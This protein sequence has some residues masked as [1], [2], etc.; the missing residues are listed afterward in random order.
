MAEYPTT[1]H[2]RQAIEK[3][4]ATLDI[5]DAHVEAITTQIFASDAM[6]NMPPGWD[7]QRLQRAALAYTRQAVYRS[8]IGRDVD[9]ITKEINDTPF[10][11]THWDFELPR[12]ITSI[13]CQTV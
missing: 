9:R 1:L 8:Q 7:H 6:R 10:R 13:D 11:H 4:L 12:R 3:E 5:P 2:I